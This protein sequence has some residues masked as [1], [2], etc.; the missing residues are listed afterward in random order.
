MMIPINYA[1]IAKFYL[2][3]M[4]YK[5]NYQ[6]QNQGKFLKVLAQ[7]LLASAE[8]FKR[9]IYLIENILAAIDYLII[10]IIIYYYGN[11]YDYGI[12]YY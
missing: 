2:A 10:S 5:N 12:I 6:K 7:L 3:K 4:V 8:F 1:R 9:Y 11:I